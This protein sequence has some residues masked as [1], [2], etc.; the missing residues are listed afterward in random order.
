MAGS[1]DKRSKL[2]CGSSVSLACGSLG[3]GDFRNARVV[4]HSEDGLCITSEL[5]FLVGATVF[6]R[7]VNGISGTSDRTG[8]CPPFRTAAVAEVKWCQEINLGGRR[9]FRIGLKYY[10][11]EY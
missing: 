5:P 1:V 7:A 10:P 9:L 8:I 4:D 11:P 3:A 2:R 6:L